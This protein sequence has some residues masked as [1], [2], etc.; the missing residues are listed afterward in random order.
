[1]KNIIMIRTDAIIQKQFLCK[2]GFKNK[3][4]AILA[5]FC[6]DERFIEPSVEF[7]QKHLKIK[8]CDLIVYP[9]GPQFIAGNE[10]DT[11]KRMKF[12][13]KA[14]NISHI[15]LISHTDCG[16]YK[17]LYS[18]LSGEKLYKQQISDI[19][20]AVQILSSL[21]KNISVESFYIKLSKSKIVVEA[22]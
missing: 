12:L 21:F 3:F 13:I 2:K 5:I 8:R 22:V 14:H 15:I 20:R 10:K 19:Q 6:S 16:Y 1:L 9:G 4:S 7:L 18:G 11:I 17:N